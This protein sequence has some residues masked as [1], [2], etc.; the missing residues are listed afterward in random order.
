MNTRLAV[1][2]VSA[3]LAACASRPPERRPPAPAAR[4]VTQ[5]VAVASAL[6]H[7]ADSTQ[8][9]DERGFAFA[10]GCLQGQPAFW[11]RYFN[12]S[13]LP[14]RGHRQDVSFMAAVEP[15]HFRQRGL[16]LLPIFAQNTND[17]GEAE[18]RVH[19]AVNARDL[20]A[21]VGAQR[22][23]RHLA[24][25]PLYVV[26]NEETP[27][28]M[29]TPEHYGGWVAGFTEALAAIGANAANLRP[30]V[31]GNVNVEPA[32]KG[33]VLRLH[34]ARDRVPYAGFWRA[35]PDPSLQWQTRPEKCGRL[36]DWHF[37]NDDWDEAVF[38][39]LLMR[40]YVLDAQGAQGES[41]DLNAINPLHQA[42]LLRG[43]L[44][45]DD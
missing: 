9:V 37:D 1:L 17:I 10:H 21:A 23:V 45:F 14:E 4:L 19:G 5:P 33:V 16:R 24:A 32:L 34:A 8:P 38:G 29:L 3:L 7:G 42:E 20:I 22:L 26:L 15:G 25:R 27:S 40:Q 11:G 43:M 12:H 41:V 39:P 6:A 2:L 30:V 13:D 44:A 36:A 35:R 31:Y 28:G 18:G